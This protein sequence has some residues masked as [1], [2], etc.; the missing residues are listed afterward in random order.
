MV[1]NAMPRIETGEPGHLCNK[2]R[3]ASSLEIKDL[4][5]SG[6]IDEMRATFQNHVGKKLCFVNLLSQ[7]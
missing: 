2:R 1:V 3:P 5:L 7:Q 6:Q 4:G